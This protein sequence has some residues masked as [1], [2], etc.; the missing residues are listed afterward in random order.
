[1]DMLVTSPPDAASLLL[2]VGRATGAQDQGELTGGG[3]HQDLGWSQGQGWPTIC[4]PSLGL[5]FPPVIGSPPG[6]EEAVPVG[7]AGA[8]PRLG[9]RREVGVSGCGAGW[10]G[11]GCQ[12]PP[13]VAPLTSRSPRSATLPQPRT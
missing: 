1:M 6:L 4:P 9:D 11:W 12:L 3:R 7:R 2:G 10:A 8:V 5:S 13:L